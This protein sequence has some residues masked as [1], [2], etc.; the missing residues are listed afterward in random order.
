MRDDLDGNV[1][2]DTEKTSNGG[3]LPYLLRGDH[4]WVR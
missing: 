3:F 4:S 1:D 2:R